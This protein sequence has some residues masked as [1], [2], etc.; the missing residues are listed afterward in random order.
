MEATLYEGSPVKYCGKDGWLDFPIKLR[1]QTGLWFELFEKH[2][3]LIV[4]DIQRAKAE[5][6][7]IIYLSCP[8]SSR[9]GS[10]GFTN[11]EIA[12]HI[13]RQLEIKWGS[14]FWVLNP[15]L[16]QMESGMGTGLIRR[17]AHLL[18][19][20]RNLVPEINV[21]K[22]LREFPV[23]GGD[24]LR[25]WARVLVEDGRRNLGN[26][27]DA[28][29]FVGPTDVWNFFANSENNG[30][31]C[32]TATNLT[33]KVEEYFARRIATNIKFRSYF[34]EA[35]E[36]EDAER[37]FFKFYTLEAGSYF[38]LGSHDEYK[39]WQILNKIRHE[40]LGPANHIP[41]YFDG[42]QIGFGSNN[43][44]YSRGYAVG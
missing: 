5:D 19:A 17:H 13:A 1:W 39:I 26:R 30:C 32:R 24:Y 34:E 16:Y 11:A 6:R 22:L 40:E 15:V 42:R 12:K 28:F 4:E 23:T 44:S 29:Y 3:D 38:S 9:G 31:N 27:F 35:R 21:E 2:V 18:S 43:T 14:R 10:Y 20:E 41:A 8:I 37:E 33:Q 7:L 36:M 25:M